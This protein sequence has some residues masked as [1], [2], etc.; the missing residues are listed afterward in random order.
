MPPTR[1]TSL[2]K[3]LANATVTPDEI[4][5]YLTIDKGL[6]HEHAMGM[7]PNIVEESEFIYNR[8]Q[9]DTKY[10][11]DHS[12]GRQGI[13]LFQYTEPTR[14]KN[15]VEA[16][17]DWQTN[18][19]S[20]ID[21]ALSEPETKKYLNQSFDTLENA[22]RYFTTDWERP[23][24]RFK[25]AEKRLEYVPDLLTQIEAQNTKPYASETFQSYV[26]P[27][28]NIIEQDPVKEYIDLNSDNT[29]NDL[30][31]QQMNYFA[32]GGARNANNANIMIN[33]TDPANFDFKSELIALAK[34]QNLSENQIKG[35]LAL[36]GIENRSGIAE[37]SA[38]YG[39]S[40]IYE[41][42]HKTLKKFGE[43]EG[44]YDSKGK[45]FNP[46]TIT[47]ADGE[48]TVAKE[49]DNWVK[50]H[51]TASSRGADGERLTN[52]EINTRQRGLFNTVYS[53]KHG[54]HLD[55]DDP[56]DGWRYRGR[57]GIQ[58]TGKA[59]YEKITKILN[60]KGIDVDLVANPEL[61]ADYKYT[62]P[63]AMAFAEKEGMF[64]PKSKKY[65]SENDYEKIAAGDPDAIDKL[66]NITNRNAPNDRL[67]TEV[68]KVFDPNGYKLDT[69]I[70]RTLDPTA[71]ALGLPTSE[72]INAEL[73]G[74]FESAEAQQAATDAYYA[75]R[76]QTGIINNIT[77]QAPAGFQTQGTPEDEARWYAENTNQEG[78]INQ[79]ANDFA[80]SQAANQLGA[81]YE[82]TAEDYARLGINSNAIARQ[83]ADDYDA[84]QIVP[85][86]ST[87][88]DFGGFD[89]A[90]EQA[91]AEKAWYDKRNQEGI[92]R[93]IANDFKGNGDIPESDF[94]DPRFLPQAPQTNIDP[95]TAEEIDAAK[96]LM[97]GREERTPSVP[98]TPV[99]Y[100]AAFQKNKTE[101]PVKRNLLAKLKGQDYA[102]MLSDIGSYAA[103]MAPLGQALRDSG[104]YDSVRYPR[105]S[106]ALPTAYTQRRDV[107][108]AFN[109]ARQAAMQQG[110]LDLNALSTLATQQAQTIAGVEEN[111]ANQRIGL[112][113]QAELTNNQTTMQEMADTAANKGAAATMR[114]QTLAAMSQMGQGSLREM[115]MRRNDAN[116]KAMFESVFDE[117]MEDYNTN[118]G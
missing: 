10:D 106:P 12:K 88:P 105:F 14:R 15:F 68:K 64:D 1:K 51:T 65:L 29:I 36:H 45:P 93:E 84:S 57:G 79:I 100:N 111:V 30:V 19:K 5:K 31:G 2:E 74:G 61:A 98:N 78:I 8:I 7:L 63:I 58:L 95:S 91:A 52:E 46:V 6:S 107:G 24:N 33:S 76:N 28:V 116:V 27:T 16:V 81:P 94:V 60:S 112:I 97:E 71:Q 53:D 25:Q 70:D 110:K 50:N 99:D 3:K 59:N 86:E 102:G 39:Y 113:N 108:T 92:L 9:N 114:Y 20:Q 40:R 26:M 73:F 48:L 101:D 22:S 83:V 42:F 13:G 66:H 35:L 115:N 62:V 85:P 18:W 17:P 75:N 11:S 44:W 109:T 56:N 90:E 80:A 69:E 77:P 89:S 49:L 87:S 21:F 67:T 82:P 96:A 23:K 4:Y 32:Q 47:Y 55:N 41:K 34:E 38:Y 37:E 54:R 43:K 103:R 117:K 72:D 118:N 104:S